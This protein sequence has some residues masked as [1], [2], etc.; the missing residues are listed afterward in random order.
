[1][2]SFAAFVEKFSDN[3]IG[4]RRLQQ[5][6]ARF[7]QRQHRDVHFFGLSRSH[8]AKHPA[9]ID[10]DKI[11]ALHRASAPR[12][13]NDRWS[14]SCFQPSIED[15]IRITL[16]LRDFPSCCCEIGLGKSD[17][18]R[19]RATFHAIASPKFRL[20]EQRFDPRARYSR[21]AA[22]VSTIPLPSFATAW[23]IDGVQPSGRCDK[24]R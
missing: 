16:V 6:D 22:K 7:A 12:F 24:L 13:P 3:G 14:R 15:R 1:M 8:A 2:Q 21:A 20:H 18:A 11:S 10:R 17:P 4:L 19:V 5:F 9:P 23:T